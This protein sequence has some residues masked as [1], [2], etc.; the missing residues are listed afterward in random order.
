MEAC[1]TAHY[2]AREIEQ[3]GHQVRLI[4]PKFMKPYVKANKNDSAYAEAI[5]EAAS[6]PSMRLGA[7]KSVAQQDVQ[8]VHRV[9]Q[10]LVKARTSLVNQARGPLAEY[11]I[12]I[13]QG[14]ATLG[15]R[16]P[17]SLKITT[18]V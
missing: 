7:V 8:A 4:G 11:G 17:R 3:L 2:W 6:R 9:R 15:A 13:A 10:Q 18:M 12:V 14:V 16:C 5:C 1:A